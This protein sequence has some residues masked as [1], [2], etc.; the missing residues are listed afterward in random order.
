M[1]GGAIPSGTDILRFP[2][3][4]PTRMDLI[5]YSSPAIINGLLMTEITS[6][7]NWN[8]PNKRQKVERFFFGYRCA[9]C[10]EVFLIRK[11]ARRMEHIER[12]IRHECDPSD[13]RR[14]VRNAREMGRDRDEY[15]MEGFD[16]RWWPEMRDRKIGYIR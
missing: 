13:I 10:Q 9:G 5:V 1:M 15:I 2:E 16:G 8:D 6:E 4:P 11:E 14:A 3:P 12:D 7:S